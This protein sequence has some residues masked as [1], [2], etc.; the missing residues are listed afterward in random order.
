[1]NTENSA[2]GA[3]I[4]PAFMDL[5]VARKT[6][7]TADVYLFELRHPQGAELPAFSPG[8]HLTVQLPNGMRRNYSL[9][10]DPAHR[11]FYQIAVKRDAKGRGGSI[12]MVDQVQA[13][14][15]LPTSVPRNNFELTRHADDY[16]FVAGGIGITPI[17]SMMRHLKSSGCGRFKLYYCTRDPAN[18]AFLA[19]LNQSEFAGQVT[20]H[21]DY[22]DLNAAFDFWD[23]FEKPSKAHV[24]CCGPSGLMDSVRD[25]S[26]H[27][28]SG[29][30]HFESFGVARAQAA[31]KA[32]TVRLQQSGATIQVAPDQ[33][34]LDALRA[35]GHRVP[36]SCESGT[37]GSCRTTL[38]AG[39]ADHRDMV[40]SEVEK[41]TQIMV[42]VSRAKSDEL[43]LDL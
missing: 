34:I 42:C 4:E 6:A 38:V 25:T 36:S 37:C 39:E 18:T 8:A 1:L 19:E 5:Q 28:P 23:I 11:D 29:S 24:Y 26:G 14:D 2:A 27:W 10:S 20:F 33:S 40:L 31:N 9:S 15:L 22:G 30:V 7:L 13:G 17:L 12:S 35:C 3:V 41:K 43:V 21:H 32:F 16:I